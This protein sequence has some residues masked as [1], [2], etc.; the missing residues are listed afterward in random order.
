MY[1]ITNLVLHIRSGDVGLHTYS[2][3]YDGPVV[4]AGGGGTDVTN[5]TTNEIVPTGP[6]GPQIPYIA[7]LFD[8][9]AQ[10]YSQGP[11]QAFGG[12]GGAGLTAPINPNLQQ[13][14][15]SIG[16]LA[17]GNIDQ[18]QAIQQ[19]L[20]TLGQGPNANAQFG[21]AQ[22]GGIQ[23]GLD[24]QFA[25][26]NNA[27]SQFGQGQAGNAQGAFN[28]IFGQEAPSQ[29][30][31]PITASGTQGGGTDVGAALGQQLAGGGGQNPYLDQLV[32]GAIQSQTD[33]FN[34][35]VLPGIRGDAQSA[36]Q[37][38]GTRQ[39]IAEGIAAGDLTNSIG[40]TTANIYG[41]AFNTQANLQG[42]AVGNVLGAQQ[43]DQSAGLTAAGLTTQ[44][45]SVGDQNYNN[46]INSLLSGTGQVGNFIGGG[47]GLGLNAVGNATGQA[48]NLFTS[49]G[50]LG[51]N[52]TFGA[53]N[54][55]PGFQAASLG[56][57][58]AQNAV[59]VQQYGFDQAGINAAADQYYFNQN[60]PY[61]NLSQ[62]QQ[63][64]SGP[65]GSSIGTA[66]ADGQPGLPPPGSDQF[67]PGPGTYLP[68]G[69]GVPQAGQPQQAKG[70]TGQVQTVPNPQPASSP[71]PGGGPI[72]GVVNQL[73]PAQQQAVQQTFQG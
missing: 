28:S 68:P 69:G 16:G 64:I 73:P 65:Y 3:W 8:Q 70:G 9:A 7:Q 50:Q 47:T 1:I 40:N 38:G 45:T 22:T 33:A 31:S 55:I 62:F 72:S 20:Q 39:G 15:D 48:G 29:D 14:Q 19:Y 60:A 54:A 6:Y 23:G 11:L 57:F 24:T 49:G 26:T 58:G 53:L 21:N 30:G 25:A 18:N 10:L 34:R 59:G 5:T 2:E 42:A 44:A 32:Q 67:G 63:F 41:N 61:Q 13:G 17:G 51:Q 4:Y 66:G 36:G 56:Q 27:L 52:Q 71:V 35:S 12:P 43:G 37:P 46:Y